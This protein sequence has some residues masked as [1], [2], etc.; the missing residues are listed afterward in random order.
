MTAARIALDHE[1]LAAL[2][3]VARPESAAWRSEIG[4]SV[5]EPGRGQQRVHGDLPLNRGM[6]RRPGLPSLALSAQCVSGGSVAWP[7]ERVIEDPSGDVVPE[8][9]A[10]R[11]IQ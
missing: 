10:R 2:D 4:V 1:D 11:V 7:T 8:L 3:G 9:E 6:W 5:P